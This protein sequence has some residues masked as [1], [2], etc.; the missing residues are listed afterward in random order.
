MGKND[1]MQAVCPVCDLTGAH[2]ISNYRGHHAIFSQCSIVRCD[3]CKMVYA[4]PMPGEA[5]LHAYNH[6]Y[7][8][9]AHGGI[10]TNK[11]TVAF[12]SAI[13]LL[14]VL[15]VEKFLAKE[16][17]QVTSVLEIGPGP[18][19]FAKHW[20]QRNT[21]T[22]E[23]TAIEADPICHNSLAALGVK[24]YQEI[25]EIPKNLSFDL[26]VI[27][28][29][30]EH[31]SHPKE[32]LRDC[33]TLLSPKGIL[34]IEVPCNDHE[35]KDTI[36]PHLL[37]FDKDPMQLL[38]T[39]TGFDHIGLTYHGNTINDL[40]KGISVYDRLFNKFRNALLT[41]GVIFLFSG[42]EPG[43]ENVHDPLERASVKPFKAH[44]E[45]GE[46]SWW[47]RAVAIKN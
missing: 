11:I 41:R 1:S 44:I 35:H 46:P 24:A 37:F 28:H 13:N 8:S 16:N 19:N 18:G 6:S 34:F 20:L 10:S 21:G 2:F 3:N 45:Q 36:E 15:H 5:D 43:L 9:N 26:V 47:L 22:V 27:S 31:T 30:L 42:I 39:K 40:E 29:V 38:L 4:Y 25:N 32:F 14:R 7:F 12:H 17:K 23:Y 33:T